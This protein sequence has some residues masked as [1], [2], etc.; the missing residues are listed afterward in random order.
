MPHGQRGEKVIAESG[1][2]SFMGNGHVKPVLGRVQLAEI[3][4]AQECGSEQRAAEATMLLLWKDLVLAS[5]GIQIR[6]IYHT[7]LIRRDGSGD[8][9]IRPRRRAV[10]KPLQGIFLHHHIRLHDKQ[11]GI[12][13]QCL[14][15]RHLQHQQVIG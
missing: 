6:I 5:L 8:G 7:V 13:R 1:L 10:E 12:L 4:L 9:T 15:L 2:Q 3:I 11:P 14:A